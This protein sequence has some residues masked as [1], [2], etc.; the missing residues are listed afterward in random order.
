VEWAASQTEPDAWI[1]GNCLSDHDGDKALTHTIAYTMRGILEVGRI[2][3][4][5]DFMELAIR[6]GGAVARAQR[7]DGALPGYLARGW[8]PAVS[9]SCLTGNSQMALNWLRMVAIA[10][11]NDFRGNALAANRF[12]M[13]TQ[14]LTSSN[15]GVR[16]GLKGSHPIDGEYMKGRYPN[17]AAKFFT[18]ALLLEELGTAAMLNAGA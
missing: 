5:P 13:A 1:E 7:T 12:N 16:G 15:P 3:V 6:M 8:R 11:R 9:W 10:E 2:A 18:D 4:R 14:D 17:W